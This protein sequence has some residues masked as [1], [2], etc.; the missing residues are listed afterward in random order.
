MAE[1]KA[2]NFQSLVISLLKGVLYL[3]NDPTLLWQCLIQ[4]QAR[5]RDHISQCLVLN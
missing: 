1:I 5:V 3:E 4:L 2:T